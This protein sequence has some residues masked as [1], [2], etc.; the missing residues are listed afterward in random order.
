MI[1]GYPHLWKPP[2][3]VHIPSDPFVN[4]NTNYGKYHHLFMGKSTILMAMAS[5]FLCPANCQFT[6]GYLP[7]ISGWWFGCHL[8]F[9]HILGISSSQ[10]TNS[11]FS[12]G[13]PNHQ[14]VFL[15]FQK[16]HEPE[17]AKLQPLGFMVIDGMG[18]GCW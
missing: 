8:L 4:V 6:R 12:E 9:S 18:D 5:M 3:M 10:L 15:Y 2:C 7:D 16:P 17:V 1:W 14:P 11:Y 13:W